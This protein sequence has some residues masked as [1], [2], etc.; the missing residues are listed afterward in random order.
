MQMEA[1]LHRQ[2]DDLIVKYKKQ[3]HVLTKLHNQIMVTLP[4]TLENYETMFREKEKQKKQENDICNEMVNKFMQES[5]DYYYCSASETFFLYDRVSYIVVTEDYVR[6]HIY[7]ILTKENVSSSLK[8]KI[9]RV[10]LKAVRE[11]NINAAIPE[12]IT[13]QNVI[14]WLCCNDTM[15]NMVKYFMT[16]VGDVILKKDVHLTYI[17]SSRMKPLIRELSNRCYEYFGG[18]NLRKR[19]RYKFHEQH[20]IADTRLLMKLEPVLQSVKTLDILCVALHYSTRYG[21]SEE[22]MKVKSYDPELTKYIYYLKEMNDPSKV[23]EDFVNSTLIKTNDSAVSIS[24]KNMLFLWKRFCEQK[25]IPSVIFYGN[26][27]NYFPE[28]YDEPSDT[29][30]GV[31]S[32]NLPMVSQFLRFWTECTYL[33]AECEYEVE[34]VCN[35]YRRWSNADTTT[36]IS[37]TMVLKLIHHFFEDVVSVEEDK[38]IYGV[39]FLPWDKNADVH[40][41]LTILKE[42][43]SGT[44]NPSVTTLYEVY[45]RYQE[46]ASTGVV[47]KRF[48]ERYIH[49]RFPAAMRENAQGIRLLNW[50]AISL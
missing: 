1:N 8:F 40:N 42:E 47:S 23:I 7:K 50:D 5:Q 19:F 9:M 13:I 44:S 2:L 37:E 28:Y 41:V 48:F 15:R 24:S 33:N 27:K 49:E 25:C 10:I 35:I 17:I 29:Y 26:L 11:R 38:Y 6:E 45:E 4:N 36:S 31:T 3:P 43:R 46:R 16:V 39:F 32:P 14:G 21:S 20:T 12:S 18:E 22:F 30:K 34:E